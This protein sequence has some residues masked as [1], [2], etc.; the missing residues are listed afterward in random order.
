M[1]RLRR[2]HPV[3]QHLAPRRPYTYLRKTDPTAQ[4]SNGEFYLRY[5]MAKESVRWLA[6]QLYPG[7]LQSQAEMVHD[8]YGGPV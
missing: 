5:R 1:E 2:L 4:Y 7:M 6:S 3:R 8:T